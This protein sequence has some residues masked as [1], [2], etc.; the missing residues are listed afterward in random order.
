MGKI[1]DLIKTEEKR[2]KETIPLIASENLAYPE[3]MAAV[4]SSLMNK[5]A[6][7]YPGKRY[8]QG[9]KIVDEIEIYAQE[10]A[11]KVWNLQAVNV[12]PYSGSPANA[13]VLLALCQPGETIAGMKLTAGGHLTHG[14][15]G[16]TFSG[17]F[18]KSEQ[19]D[20]DKNGR[21]DYESARELILRTK[22]K[23][24]FVGTTAYPWKL[25]F[26][27]FA[28]VALEVGAFVVADIAHISGLVATGL[29]PGIEKVDIV[30]TTTHKQLRGPRGALIGVTK[31]GILKNPEL[32]KLID[33]AVFPGLQGGPHVETIAGIAVALEKALTSEYK[34]Y[35]Q[36]IIINA[37]VMQET[38]EDLGLKVYGTE[39]HLMVVAVGVGR[40]KEVAMKL[41][42]ERIICNY[43][44]IPHDT[45]PPFS[46]SGIRL[47]VNAITSLG[48]KEKETKALAKK[49]TEIIGKI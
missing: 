11:K 27:F 6:E 20:V 43:N 25:D 30:T 42:E 31:A 35:C 23:V 2:Q 34:N 29:H 44:T 16:I 15:P 38:L 9:N 17:K 22:P 45:A 48:Y 13:A 49:I 36:Q 47:G 7:G 8:Y 46:P 26:D 18:F 28:K 33:R 21:I 3:V 4:G 5:Y 37:K 12:Q 24:I 32:P 14:H 39:N 40:G 19:W 10:L 41:E 1:Q